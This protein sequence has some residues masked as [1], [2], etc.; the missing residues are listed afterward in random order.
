MEAE[1][2]GKRGTKMQLQDPAKGENQKWFL[3]PADGEFYYI[4]NESQRYMIHID[5]PISSETHIK[6]EKNQWVK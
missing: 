6:L 2:D 4:F 5:C 1:R 3:L